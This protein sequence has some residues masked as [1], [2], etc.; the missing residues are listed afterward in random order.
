V[1]HGLGQENPCFHETV[2]YGNGDYNYIESDEKTSMYGNWQFVK[3]C[4]DVVPIPLSSPYGFLQLTEYEKYQFSV[5]AWRAVQPTYDPKSGFSGVNMLLESRELV[6]MPGQIRSVAKR[7]SDLIHRHDLALV[8]VSKPLAELRLMSEY[9]TKPLANDI[10]ALTVLAEQS[11]GRL[12]R[13]NRQGDQ[14]NGLHYAEDLVPSLARYDYGRLVDYRERRGRYHGGLRCRYR[15]AAEDL[16]SSLLAYYG[17]TLSPAQIWE[18]TPF[19]FLVDH[20]IDVGKTLERLSRTAVTEITRGDFVES[21][22]YNT[23]Y[24][25]CFKSEP[26]GSNIR[27]FQGGCS[28]RGIDCGTDHPIAWYERQSYDR[29]ISRPPAVGGV[30]LPRFKY[31]TIKQLVNDLALAR[32]KVGWQPSHSRIHYA[33][34]D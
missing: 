30:P 18:A 2:K 14:W 27:Y 8:D 28:P 6:R 11:A 17:L 21:Y 31:P 23:A 4:R 20:V 29:Y 24:V 12:A 32:T 15:Q 22:T 1:Q 5:R 7:L 3:G 33:V 16:G 34:K 9:G 25:R 19:S 13:F 10:A 26:N